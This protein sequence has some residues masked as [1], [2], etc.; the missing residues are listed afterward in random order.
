MKPPGLQLHENI[1][2]GDYSKGSKFK[3]LP[4]RTTFP[5]TNV[6]KIKTIEDLLYGF[7]KKLELIVTDGVEVESSGYRGG[8][9][10]LPFSKNK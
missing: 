1:F 2:Y 3:W 5:F 6:I 9:V 4:Q 10:Q 8:D 7:V